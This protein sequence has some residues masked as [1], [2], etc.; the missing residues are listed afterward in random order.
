MRKQRQ[1]STSFKLHLALNDKA[2]SLKALR[3]P[4][5]TQKRYFFQPSHWAD[6]NEERWQQ[7][8]ESLVIR[9]PGFR[10]VGDE[11]FI[12]SLASGLPVHSAQSPLQKTVS[13]PRAQCVL[14]L[15]WAQE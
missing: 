12:N 3:H 9:K 5:L 14:G 1:F 13:V 2:A 10:S 8:T 6:T 15:R 4:L 7:V 11:D